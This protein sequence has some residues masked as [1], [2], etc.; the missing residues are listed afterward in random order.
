MTLSQFCF[1][2]GAVAVLSSACGTDPRPTDENQLINASYGSV[3]DPQVVVDAS[4]GC[5]RSVS[6]A[7]LSMSDLGDF[8][9]S[10]NTI[11]DCTQA[12]GGFTFGEVLHLGSYTRASDHLSFTPDNAHSPLFTGTIE[13][14]FIRLTL[15]SATGISTHQVELVVG[16]REPL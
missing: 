9:L 11:D 5:Q 4:G 15:P 7:V 2:I 3:Y 12:G 10:V 14:E 13:G 6:H 1:A 16:P 8:D